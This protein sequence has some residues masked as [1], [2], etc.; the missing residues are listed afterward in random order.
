MRMEWSNH[1]DITIE[2][3]KPISIQHFFCVLCPS[4]F[5]QCNLN[6]TAHFEDSY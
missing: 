6:G 5:F 4:S 3:I 1:R 2:L